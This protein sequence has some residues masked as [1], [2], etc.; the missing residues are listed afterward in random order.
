MIE[1][2]KLDQLK[3]NF[4][5]EADCRKKQPEIQYDMD[6]DML[7]LYF[8]D[9]TDK[10]GPIIA[11]YLDQNV[12][13]LFRNSDLEIVGFSIEGVTRSFASSYG[14]TKPWRLSRTG[15]KI[16]GIIDAVMCVDVAKKTELAIPVRIQEE[17]Q[18]K[19]EYAFA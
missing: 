17:I 8:A 9:P 3:T 12:A 14:R 4:W 6:A 16:T 15:V 19:P 10:P 13:L 1:E 18:L 2:I 11:H 5:R 7:D